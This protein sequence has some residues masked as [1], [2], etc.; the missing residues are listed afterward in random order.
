M[1]E[2]TRLCDICKQKATHTHEDLA[3]IFDHDQEDGKSKVKPYFS[4]QD[5]DLCEVHN[6]WLMAGHYIFGYGAMG[7]NNYFFK[8]DVKE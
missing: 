1:R 4:Y 2:I 5:I 6:N 7:F 8:T 3:V